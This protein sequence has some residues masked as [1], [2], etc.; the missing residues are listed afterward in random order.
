MGKK[1]GKHWQRLRIRSG[2]VEQGI[3]VNDPDII[4]ATRDLI[5]AFDGL[6]GVFCCQCRITAGG[7]IL[8]FELNPRFGGGVPLSVAA[9]AH[10]PLYLLQDLFGMEITTDGSF[11]KT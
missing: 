6:W 5:G 7:E 4:Q 1:R 10:L 9:G 8:F 11:R 2:E 3:T